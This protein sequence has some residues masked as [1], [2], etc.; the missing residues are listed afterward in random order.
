MHLLGLLTVVSVASAARA[1]ETE[2]IRIEYQAARGAGCPSERDFTAQVFARTKSARRAAPD[3]P[4]R[5]F[6]V[7]LRR[8]GSHVVG[9]LVIQETDGATMAR[10][11]NGLGCTDVATVLALATALAIDPRAELAPLETLDESREPAAAG[12]SVPSEP[13]EDTT[14]WAPVEGDVAN[15]DDWYDGYDDASN[16]GPS[17][18]VPRWAVGATAAFAVT[19]HPAWG[20]SLLFALHRSRPSRGPLGEAGVELAYRNAGSSVVADAK[21]AFQFYVARPTLCASGVGL[22]AASSLA[23]C[24]VIEL[25]AVTGTG[26]QIPNSAE[27]T[28]F[29]ASAELQFR[30]EL[31]LGDAW[32]FTLEAGPAVPLTRYQ[33]VFD[34]PNTEIH[35]VPAIAVTGALRMGASF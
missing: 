15:P 32:F 25:G 23:P 28:N 9:S 12:G 6:K 7:Q 16:H 21:A 8:S 35:E 10:R 29:W 24:F 33:F 26:S 1:D 18:W 30:L 14:T 19:P 31:A 20:A 22:G 17:R 27:R 13:P 4:A 2:P 11:V 5:T 34:N 3:E